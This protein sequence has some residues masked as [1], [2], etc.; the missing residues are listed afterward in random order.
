[1]SQGKYRPNT[2]GKEILSEKN[3]IVPSM[4]SKVGII[5]GDPGV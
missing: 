4:T 3:S 1:M 5:A 2:S